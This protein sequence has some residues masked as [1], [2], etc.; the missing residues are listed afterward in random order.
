VIDPQRWREVDEVFAKALDCPPVE[1]PALL[2]RA[3]AGRPALRREVERLL[4]ADE[5]GAGFLE[6]PPGELLALALDDGEEGGTLGPYRLLRRIG[7]GG[8]GTVYL[9]RRDDGHY[10]RD[11]AVKVLRSGLASTEARH[12]FLA[13]RQILARLEHPNIARLYDG[14]CTADGRP[15]L[16]MELVAG[17]PVDEYCDRH[18]LTVDQRLLLF[19]KICAAVQ[20]AHQNLLV[21]RDLKPGNILITAEGEPKLLDFGIAKRLAPEAGEAL[22][23]LQETRHGMRMLT[24]GYASPEQVKGEAIT[25]ASDV[26]ALGVILYELLAGRR[27]YRVQAELPYELERAICEQEP[28]R[29]SLALFQAGPPGVEEIAQDR[30]ARPQALSHRLR[31]DLDNV[32]FMALRKDPRARYGSAAQLAEDLEKHLQDLPVAARPDTLR[33]RA[34]KLV[35]RH[36]TAVGVTAAVVLLVAASVAG[37][38]GQGRQLARERDKARYALS[39]LVDVFKQADP[40]QAKGERLTAREILDQGAERISRELAG[41]PDVQAA[42]MDAIGE[43]DLGLGRNDQAGPLLERALALRRRIFGFGSL[44]VAESLEHVAELRLQRSDRPGAESRLREALTIRRRRQGEGDIAVAKTMNLLGGALVE[45]GVSPAAAPEIEA[46]HREALA[47]AV[48]VEGP[49]GLTVAETLLGLSELQQALGSYGEAERLFR[50]GLAVERRAL[51][52][53]APRLWRDQTDLGDVLIDA[54]KL[55]EAEALLRKC[56]SVQQKILDRE[57]PDLVITMVNLAQAV[58]RQGRYAEAEALDREALAMARTIYG[59]T[60]SIVAIVLGNLASDIHAQSRGAEAIRYYEQALALRRR[61]FGD[62]DPLVG[63]NLLLLAGLYREGLR[64][65]EALQLAEQALAILEKAEGPDHP[66]VAYPLREIGRNYLQQRRFREAEP[67]LRRSLEIRRKKLAAGNPELAKAQVSL[68]KCLLGLGRDDEAEGL[69]R[70]ARPVLLSAFDPG[71]EIAREPDEL[72]AE[73]E[74]RRRSR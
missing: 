8:M 49:N 21:H 44:P 48:A 27:P 70:E 13:E 39:F 51:G 55:K 35:R 62:S 23:A 42:V 50:Q 28:E 41:E 64:Y 72:L 24:P 6:S 16:V 30:R 15:Y 26:Y 25:T 66:R 29:P 73:I 59:P 5:E 47:I 22:E 45:K 56:L 4:A 2:D 54:G 69:L 36:R 38:I 40:Y 19:R 71:Q 34:R 31:G 68:A 57:H 18:R 37:L 1:R 65:A 53:R 11:V 12:R 33:Y 10:R 60:H 43:V 9:A 3:C 46:L 74:R 67:F 14:G 52:D 61:A 20:H 58:H 7:S 32:V 63:Q 17:M